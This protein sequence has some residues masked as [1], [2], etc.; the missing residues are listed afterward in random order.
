ME[1]TVIRSSRRSVSLQVKPDGTVVVRAPRL[2]PQRE[3]RRFVESHSTW[4]QKQLAKL[5][6]ARQLQGEIVP[7]SKEELKVVTE[8]ARQDL[9]RRCEY[10]SAIIGVT[11]GRISIRHQKSKWG[12]CSSKG[13]L[14]FNCLLMFAPD[15]VR[16]YVVVH[17]LCHRKHMNHSSAFWET[18]EH[19]LPNWKEAKNWLRINE[20]TLMLRNP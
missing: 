4:I 6:A 13:N 5:A 11:Y 8:S 7:L 12:S 14:N 10:W 3:I 1:I 15:E 19:F 16:D 18:V 20:K 17:E 9:T 2:F